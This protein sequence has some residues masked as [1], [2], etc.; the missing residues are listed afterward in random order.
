MQFIRYTTI[1]VNICLLLIT[2]LFLLDVFT[3]FDIVS[4]RLKSF[5]YWGF[6][7]LSPKL[8][9]WNF[10]AISSRRLKILGTGWAMVLVP[11]MLYLGPLKIIF[12]TG[13]WQSHTVLFQHKHQSNKKIELQ[14]QDL[15]ALGYNWRT[16]E[17]CYWL[18]FLVYVEEWDQD[19]VKNENWQKLVDSKNSPMPT[20]NVKIP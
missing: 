18:T 15:G 3:P 10:L 4:Q 5:T 14:R 19:Q 2:G 17:A 12:A 8:V 7:I 1:F 16:V 13:A 9:V 11:L 6:L 20:E